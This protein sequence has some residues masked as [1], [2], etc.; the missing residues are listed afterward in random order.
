LVERMHGVH[1]AARFDSCHPDQNWL[2][3]FW[4][5]KEY[6]PRPCFRRPWISYF[7]SQNLLQKKEELCLPRPPVRTQ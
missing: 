2:S 6:P 5:E 1:E 4:D 3:R 7:A